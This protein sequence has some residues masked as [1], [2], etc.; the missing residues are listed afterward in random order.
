MNSVKKILVGIAYGCSIVVAPLAISSAAHA[1]QVTP[2]ECFSTEEAVETFSEVP[3]CDLGVDKQVSFNGGAFVEADTSSTAAQGQVGQTVTWKIIVTDNSTQGFGAQG[4]VYVK[5]VLPSGVSYVSSSATAGQYHTSGTFANEWVLPLQNDDTF[6]SNLPATLTLTT[7][8]TSTGLFENTASLAAYG[9]V[10]TADGFTVP[11]SDSTSA[12]NSNDAW[13]D[14]SAKPVV[15]AASTTKPTSTPAELTN[16]GSG[17]VESLIAGGL[18]IATAAVLV[19]RKP[20]LLRF[21]R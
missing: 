18:I 12:N 1:A 13:I 4:T 17:I 7:K 6:S 11:Y 2:L 3:S 20:Q 5:D 10:D 14:P 15:L 21:K 9:P 19:G 16:T 8:A